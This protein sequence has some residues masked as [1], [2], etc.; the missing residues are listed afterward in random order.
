MSDD[1]LQHREPGRGQILFGALFLVISVALLAVLPDQTKWLKGKAL[2]SQPR[3][4]SGIGVGGMVLFTTAHL[5]TLPRR[6]RQDPFWLQ[7]LPRHLRDGAWLGKVERALWLAIGVL[8]LAIGGWRLALPVL[9]GL[10]ALR[11]AWQVWSHDDGREARIWIG[12]VEWTGWFMAYVLAVPWAGYL[13][14]TLVFA[15]ALTWRMGYRSRFMLG[16]SVLFAIAVVVLFKT[17]LQVKIPGGALYEYLP[18]SLRNF[19]IL[20]F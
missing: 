19:M 14:V 5:L 13:P 15:P 16:I 20:N 10:A 2:F 3:F 7:R 11:L 18:A 6:A 12:A 1:P 9:A 8:T 4:W 17:F